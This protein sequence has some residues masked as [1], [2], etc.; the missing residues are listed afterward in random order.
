MG[1]REASVGV[2]R[3]PEIGQGPGQGAR[4]REQTQGRP[5]VSTDTVYFHPPQYILQS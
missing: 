2:L 3:E 4:S 1:G 5:D